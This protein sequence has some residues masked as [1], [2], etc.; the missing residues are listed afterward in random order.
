MG[1]TTTESIK[2]SAPIRCNLGHPALGGVVVEGK[3]SKCA[4]G[5]TLELILLMIGEIEEPAPELPPLIAAD[6][7]DQ[8]RGR[9]HP[10]AVA[11]L[12][13]LRGRP[14]TGEGV[15]AVLDEADSTFG[16]DARPWGH[17]PTSRWEAKESL[18][19]PSIPPPAGVEDLAFAGA[20][21]PLR[22]GKMAKRKSPESYD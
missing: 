18:R 1:M 6:P 8:Q 10:G 3:C 19:E 14:A 22:S 7:M 9:P 21:P 17:E 13:K 2:A 12:G 20:K 11:V 15:K 16:I 4:L 5:G